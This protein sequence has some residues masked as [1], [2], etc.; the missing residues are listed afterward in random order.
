MGA[1]HPLR[2]RLSDPGA[3]EELLKKHSDYETMGQKAAAA[4][5]CFDLYVNSG[6]KYVDL[7]SLSTSAS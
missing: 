3:K 2:Y 5:L 7:A 1:L 6:L 4:S